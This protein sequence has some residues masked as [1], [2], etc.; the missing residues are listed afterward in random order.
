MVGTVVLFCHDESMSKPAGKRPVRVGVVG[1]GRFG[2]LH[3]LTLNRLAEAELVAIVL[4][5]GA[6][7]VSGPLFGAAAFVVLEELLSGVTEHW[8][9]VF[10]PLLVLVVLFARGGLTGLLNGR[11][12]D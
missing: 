9:I 8:R 4:L 2:R 7:T 12:N 11:R 1:W 3:A 10:G 5:G 6:G